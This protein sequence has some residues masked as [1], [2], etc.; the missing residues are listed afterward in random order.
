MFTPIVRETAKIDTFVGLSPSFQSED[1]N[2]MLWRY[3]GETIAMRRATGEAGWMWWRNRK[4]L[5]RFM[6]SEIPS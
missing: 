5:P 2:S 1:F 3:N 4:P 6:C